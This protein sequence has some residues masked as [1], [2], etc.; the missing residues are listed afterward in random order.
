MLDGSSE[1]APAYALKTQPQSAD[2]G[3]QVDEPEGGR[4]VAE[5]SRRVADPG[6]TTGKQVHLRINPVST[7]GSLTHVRPDDPSA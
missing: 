2:P 3:E 4:R 6:V 7:H 5:R 1:T